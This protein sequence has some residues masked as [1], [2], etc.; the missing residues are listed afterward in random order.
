MSNRDEYYNRAKQEGYRARS[1]YKLKQIDAAE[2]V[3]GRGDTVVDL[4]AAPGGWLQVASEAVGD[5]GRVVGVDRQQIEPLDAATVETIRGDMTDERTRDRLR[6]ALGVPGAAPNDRRTTSSLGSSSELRASDEIETGAAA[7]SA[8]DDGED[9][10]GTGDADAA[11]RDD[12]DATGATASGGADGPRA[13]PADVV[14]SDMAPNMTGE[15]ALDHARSIHLARQAFETALTVLGTGG[16]F[17]VKVFD[18][19]DLTDFQAELAESFEYVRSLDPDA[20]RQESSERFLIGKQRLDAPVET[21]ERREV[22]VTDTG[23]EGDGIAV[24]DGYTLFVPDA[25]PGETVAVEV[26][27]VKANFGFAERLE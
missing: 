27:D 4:G 13:R 22:E 21:G 11:D 15:Y 12:A 23:E 2:D 8:A 7:A 9:A 5:A 17:V 26:T 6:A 1:A 25:E 20:S 14:V 19:R 10:V 18:G 24:V 3:L 16:D